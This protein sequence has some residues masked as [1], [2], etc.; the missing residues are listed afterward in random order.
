MP[1]RISPAVL[2]TATRYGLKPFLGPP[3]PIA[4]QRAWLRLVAKVNSPSPHAEMERI[5]M[6]GV[7]ALV[8]RP[9]GERPT[10]AMLYMH[11]G[12]YCIGGP[13]THKGLVTHL[14]VAA[15]ASVYVPDYRLAPEHPHPAALEDGLNAY[16]WMLDHQLSPRRISIA[17]DSAGGGL[18]LA[19]ALAIRDEALPQPAA[20]V[21][22]SPWTDMSCNSASRAANAKIDPMIRTSWSKRC[23]A[24]YLDG[25][26]P[27]D[28]ACSP[29]F[30]DHKGLPPMLIQV[31]T[32]EVLI[33][34]ST[35]LANRCQAAGVDV[36][37]QVFDDMW[38]VFQSSV[39]AMRE[40]DEAVAKIANFL[41]SRWS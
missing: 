22:I 28:P 23:A 13:S 1:K 10:Q 3:W 7:R 33:D 36:T 26:P 39:G 32:D 31:G 2:R 35:A 4:F 41:R 29:L 25:R 8:A 30:A 21:L 37:L 14:A 17:G 24:L 15:G 20:V 18:A 6:G 19:T 5:S 40:A 11:G 38:H 34:D 9:R 16:R 12:A 27:D